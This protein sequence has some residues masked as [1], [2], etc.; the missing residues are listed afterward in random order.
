MQFCHFTLRN[1]MIWILLLSLGGTHPLMVTDCQYPPDCQFH[2]KYCLNFPYQIPLTKRSHNNNFHICFE[3]SHCTLPEPEKMT[4]LATLPRVK[5][6]NAFL[7]TNACEG[8][9]HAPVLELCQTGIDLLALHLETRLSGVNGKCTWKMEDKQDNI[10]QQ[11]CISP[12]P[13]MNQF[14]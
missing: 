3:L 13:G 4:K 8:M 12:E 6:T 1:T 5:C 11:I 10:E 14:P 9:E 2:E 7:F